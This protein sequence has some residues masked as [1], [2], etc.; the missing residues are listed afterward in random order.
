M[1]QFAQYGMAAAEEALRDAD[2]MPVDGEQRE[3][4]VRFYVWYKCNRA[5]R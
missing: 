2:W 4:T 1:A 3:N 5:V